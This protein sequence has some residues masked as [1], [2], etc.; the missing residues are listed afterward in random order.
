MTLIAGLG[1]SLVVT[2][3]LRTVTFTVPTFLQLGELCRVT[4]LTDFVAEIVLEGR[5]Y[6]I[7]AVNTFRINITSGCPVGM[8]DT[9]T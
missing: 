7:V 4:V 6:R 2:M 8:L 5:L 3:T 9:M 1:H